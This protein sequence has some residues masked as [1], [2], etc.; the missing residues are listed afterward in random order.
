MKGLGCYLHIVGSHGTAQIT[1]GPYPGAHGLSGP[2]P[3]F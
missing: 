1:G 3:A 2:V